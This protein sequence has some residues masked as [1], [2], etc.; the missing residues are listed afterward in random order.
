MEQ[1]IDD[2]NSR[3]TNENTSNPGARLVFEN[4]QTD[5]QEANDTNKENKNMNVDADKGGLHKSFSIYL[6]TRSDLVEEI[7]LS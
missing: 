2:L 1:I 6:I 4:I 7:R 5:I 3:I